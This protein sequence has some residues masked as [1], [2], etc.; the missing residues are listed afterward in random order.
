MRAL[1]SKTGAVTNPAVAW[2]AERKA[3]VRPERLSH[4]PEAVNV[5][6]PTFDECCI[7][8]TLIIGFDKWPQCSVAS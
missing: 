1:L 7:N 5:D 8:A 6:A 4:E 2:S 3:A